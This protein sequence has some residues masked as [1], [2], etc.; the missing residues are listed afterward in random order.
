MTI[1]KL[2][3]EHGEILVD[4]TGLSESFRIATMD[5]AQTSLYQAAAD[6]AIL[7]RA[8][9]GIITERA[10]FVSISFSHGDEPG[11]RVLLSMPTFVGDPAKIACPKISAAIVKDH[12]TGLALEGE[13]R[14]VYNAAVTRLEKEIIEFVKGKRAQMALPFDCSP[15]ERELDRRE[16]AFLGQKIGDDLLIEESAANIV[17]FSSATASAQ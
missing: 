2:K 16:K 8:A 5:E 9:L 11:T 4:Y 7:A 12:E 17:E 10:G 1:D 3:L 13:P 15:Q 6:V 14:N